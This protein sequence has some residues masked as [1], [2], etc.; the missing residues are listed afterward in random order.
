[1]FTALPQHRVRNGLAV[2]PPSQVVLVD[3]AAEQLERAAAGM[4]LSLGKIVKRG[5]LKEEPE[6]VL[7]RLQHATDLEVRAL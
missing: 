7:Q 5:M 1:V 4:R 3:R 6:A 2:V